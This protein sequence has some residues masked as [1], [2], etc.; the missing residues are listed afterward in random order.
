MLE[1]AEGD[2]KEPKEPG[3]KRKRKSPKP[4]SSVAAEPGEEMNPQGRQKKK[5]TAEEWAEMT[6]AAKDY[7]HSGSD[8]TCTAFVLH[9]KV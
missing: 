9:C 8:T 4:P 7:S 6:E 2:D 3:Q 5:R 1:Y